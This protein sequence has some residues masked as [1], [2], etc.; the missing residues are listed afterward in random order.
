MTKQEFI[1]K[2]RLVDK[3]ADDNQVFTYFDLNGIED[4]TAISNEDYQT[5]EMVY[6]FHPAISETAGKMQIAQIYAYGGMS[7]IKDMVPTAVKARRIEAELR[8]LKAKEHN[9]T[10]E[11]A[12]LKRGEEVQM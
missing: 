3:M 4:M 7:V 6:A 8:E 11:L 1:E 9:L 5:I 12:R 10:E 2:L